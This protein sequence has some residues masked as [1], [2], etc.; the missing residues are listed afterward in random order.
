MTFSLATIWYERNRFLPGILA[1]P[2]AFKWFQWLPMQWVKVVVIFVVAYASITML[3]SAYRE[4]GTAL[5]ARPASLEG[6][7]AEA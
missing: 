1:V 7:G 3:L 5:A 6:A 2:L 4:R